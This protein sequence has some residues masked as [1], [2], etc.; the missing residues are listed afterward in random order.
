MLTYEEKNESNNQNINNDDNI[1]ININNEPK[2][3]LHLSVIAEVNPMFMQLIKFG[4]DKIYSRR[5][6]YYL[7]PEDIEEALNYMSEENGIIQHRFVQNRRD[8]SCKFCYICGDDKKHHLK[9]LN[10]NRN[11]NN[12]ENKINNNSNKEEEKVADKNVNTNIN[13]D[14]IKKNN[15]INEE[16]KRSNYSLGNTY[17]RES[18]IKINKSNSVDLGSQ[19][20]FKKLGEEK[21]KKVNNNENNSSAKNSIK[22]SNN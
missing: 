17:L 11:N 1:N 14:Q 8:L 12:N 6:I 13:I 19:L 18:D 21:E 7:H 2:A 5:I 15:N 9:E 4:Y 16:E 20:S 3:K 22:F 10:A